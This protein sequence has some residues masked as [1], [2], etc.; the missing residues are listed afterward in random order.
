M[1]R[2]TYAVKQHGQFALTC[3]VLDIWLPVQL[4]SH[5]L[6]DVRSAVT[7]LVMRPMVHKN[8]LTRRTG[9]ET[10]K[11]LSVFPDETNMDAPA[12]ECTELH[13]AYFA[14]GNGKGEDSGRDGLQDVAELGPAAEGSE[15][16]T[17]RTGRTNVSLL[18]RI[19][20]FSSWHQHVVHTV[21]T[22]IDIQTTQNLRN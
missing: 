10:C 8:Q 2:Q 17:E 14:D 9:M 15:M 4:V 21:I 16:A 18:R 7:G 12:R 6:T 13:Y 11:K 19:W 22:R 20:P 5:Y 1:E 3:G